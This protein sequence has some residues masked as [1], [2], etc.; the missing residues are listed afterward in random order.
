M[1]PA[2]SDATKAIT[3]AMSSGVPAEV[4]AQCGGSGQAGRAFDAE[5]QAPADSSSH[6]GN[7]PPAAANAS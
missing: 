1:Y 3:L 6:I 7:D 2:S 4:R 5:W